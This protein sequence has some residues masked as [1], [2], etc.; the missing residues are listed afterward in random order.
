VGGSQKARHLF[1]I[2][3]HL[4]AAER[5][6]QLPER[7]PLAIASCGNAA[8]AAATLAAAADW[9]IDVYVPDMDERRLR[10]RTRSARCPTPPL[11][12]ACR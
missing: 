10:C 4:L 8:L 9:P 1:T 3:L 7:P 5:L 11:R 6:G 2:L 12:T